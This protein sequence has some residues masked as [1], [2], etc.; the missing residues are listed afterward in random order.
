MPAGLG[1]A[2][3]REL[4]AAFLAEFDAGPA[5]EISR[6]FEA[7]DRALEAA[8]GETVLWFEHDLYD[9]LQVLQVLDRLTPEQ[10]VTAI[11]KATGITAAN[12]SKHLRVLRE[13]ELVTRRKDGMQV[14]YRLHDPVVQKLCELVCESLLESFDS[15]QG[16]G[17]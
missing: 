13:G 14:F 5:A 7:R 1:L 11:T 15:E 2:E 17:T 8:R 10:N 12:A 3:M 9:Q 16:E 4:R 6:A